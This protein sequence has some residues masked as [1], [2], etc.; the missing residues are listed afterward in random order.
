MKDVLECP[1]FL[2]YIIYHSVHL[3][4]SGALSVIRIYHRPN[5]CKAFYTT[6]FYEISFMNKNKPISIDF[7]C[8]FQNLILCNFILFI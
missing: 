1:C 6:K 3:F 7:Y 4:I 8:I 2:D 5:F